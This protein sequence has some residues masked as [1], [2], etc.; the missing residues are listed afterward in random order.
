MRLFLP[1]M[2]RNLLQLL[3]FC[4]MIMMMCFGVSAHFAVAAPYVT[5]WYAAAPM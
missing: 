4:M 2:K 1:M 3:R 5:L